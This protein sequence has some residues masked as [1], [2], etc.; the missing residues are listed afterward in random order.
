[1]NDEQLAAY[2]K[3]TDFEKVVKNLGHRCPWPTPTLE[4]LAYT[5]HKSAKS[6]FSKTVVHL[7]RKGEVQGENPR[8]QGAPQYPRGGTA[9][10]WACENSV[11]ENSFR[12]SLFFKQIKLASILSPRVILK[13][14]FRSIW[15][16]TFNY[17]KCPQADSVG[18]LVET[19]LED[20]PGNAMDVDELGRLPLHCAAM[21][22]QPLGNSCQIQREGEN[23]TMVHS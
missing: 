10:H 22:K 1:M 9:L 7:F 15:F 13:P 18:R 19:I 16:F 12:P 4:D 6:P 20:A 3:E 23:M 8:R 11:H 14:H 2:A 21:S 17:L 5:G